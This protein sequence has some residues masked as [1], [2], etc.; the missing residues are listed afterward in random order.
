MEKYSDKQLINIL[1]D[2]MHLNHAL[3][4]MDSII[5]FHNT[6]VSFVSL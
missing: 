1:W 2:Y 4:K 3:K 6:P 5:V